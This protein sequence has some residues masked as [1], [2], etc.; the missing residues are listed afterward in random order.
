MTQCKRCEVRMIRTQHLEQERIG[1]IMRCVQVH[2]AECPVCSIIITVTIPV[3]ES[4][5]EQHSL[6]P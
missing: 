6:S 5:T 1:E 2:I 4:S 3:L